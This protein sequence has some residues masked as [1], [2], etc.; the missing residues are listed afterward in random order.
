M[1]AMVPPCFLLVLHFLSREKKTKQKKT[2]V[3]RLTLRVVDA[4]GA[5]RNSLRSNSP[6]AFIR[7][8]RR[9]SARDKG[10]TKTQ[11][12]QTVQIPLAE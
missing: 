8:L 9:C 11:S 6:R 12:L 1:V 10:D 5:R 4:T 2:P 3:S 7:S